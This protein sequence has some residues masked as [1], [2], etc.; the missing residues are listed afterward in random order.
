[1]VNAERDYT[2]QQANELCGSCHSRARS[3][4]NGLH[5]YP[6]DETTGDDYSRHLGEPLSNFMTPDPGLWPDGKTSKKHHQQMQDLMKSSK[7][8]FAY[9]RIV[10]TT[11]HSPHGYQPKQIVSE[12]TLPSTVNPSTMLTISTKVEDNTLCLACHAGYG[13]FD[14][15]KREDIMDAAKNDA[16]IDGVVTQHCH[17]TYDPA[18]ST[19]L[20]RCTECHMAKMA[21]SGDPYDISSHTFEA[22]PPTKTIQYQAK[23]GMPNSCAVRCHRPLA[24]LFGLPVDASLTTWNEPSDLVLSQWLAKYYGPEGTWWKT[25]Q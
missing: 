5:E 13:P 18:G 4:P 11:C 6:M 9:E 1:M 21:A 19:R 16:L 15:L 24:P 14:K 17:Y 12:I 20:S 2:A 25:A 22:V 7:W 10:C 3:V 8:N 23:G